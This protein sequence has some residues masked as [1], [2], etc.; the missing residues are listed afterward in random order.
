MIVSLCYITPNKPGKFEQEQNLRTH[1]ARNDIPCGKNNNLV[2][3]KELI[4][5]RQRVAM[6]Y[7]TVDDRTTKWMSSALG[8]SHST[9]TTYCIAIIRV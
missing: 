8:V 5:Q 6:R 3:R 1:N 4:T 9:M 2:Q 7:D